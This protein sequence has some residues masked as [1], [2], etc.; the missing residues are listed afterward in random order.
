[1]KVELN[2]A[3]LACLVCEVAGVAAHIE[4]RVPAAFLM[5]IDPNL[6]ATEAKIFFLIARR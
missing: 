3:D 1:M 5:N 6:V 2:L 4:G